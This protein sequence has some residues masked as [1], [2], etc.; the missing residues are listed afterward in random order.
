MSI[1]KDTKSR[2]F[3]SVSE[4]TVVNLMFT[5]FSVRKE[6]NSFLKDFNLSEPQYNILR[7]LRGSYP[8]ELSCSDIQGLMLQGSSN[9][10]RLVDRL[11]KKGFVYS[12]LSGEDKR[13]RLCLLTDSGAMYLGFLDYKIDKFC[14]QFFKG[15][16]KEDIAMMNEMLD[17]IRLKIEQ[18]PK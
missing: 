2:K 4:K 15:L 13:K 16:K 3:L 8:K 18:D 10:T 17:E 9:V 11:I 5:A 7:I 6:A 1:E 14:A 12:E